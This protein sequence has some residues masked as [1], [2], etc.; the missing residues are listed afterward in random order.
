MAGARLMTIDGKY[1]EAFRATKYLDANMNAQLDF[2]LHIGSGERKRKVKR[3]PTA[4][5]SAP[6]KYMSFNV[7]LTWQKGRAFSFFPW[8]G[9]VI[10]CWARS[11]WTNL[12]CQDTREYKIPMTEIE[13]VI[14][15]WAPW[16]YR[17][18]PKQL[19]LSGYYCTRGMTTMKKWTPSKIPYGPLEDFQQIWVNH[20]GDFG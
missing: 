1:P 17:R 10:I 6:Q 20:V 9:Y 12:F 14:C 2:W 15:I 18:K 16:S 5:M 13:D 4:F 19:H 7:Y 11:W 8:R 3:I